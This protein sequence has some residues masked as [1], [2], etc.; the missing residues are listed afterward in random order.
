MKFGSQVEFRR[1][2]GISISYLGEYGGPG[3]PGGW[4][5]GCAIAR[6]NA[7]TERISSAESTR[8]YG[9][10]IADLPRALPPKVIMFCM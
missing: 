6:A 3:R 8:P 5:G 2:Q 7:I 4:Y 1:R 9:G 10:I